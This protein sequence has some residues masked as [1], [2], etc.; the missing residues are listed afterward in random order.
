MRDERYDDFLTSRAKEMVKYL[1]EL[2]INVCLFDSADSESDAS[3]R[4]EDDQ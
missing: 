2:N 4:I 1:K 3:V